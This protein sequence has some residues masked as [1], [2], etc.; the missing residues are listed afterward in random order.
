[1][2]WSTSFSVSGSRRLGRMPDRGILHAQSEQLQEVERIDRRLDVPRLDAELRAGNAHASAGA[3]LRDAEAQREHAR[4]VDEDARTA[5]LEV[6]RAAMRGS[7][8]VANA[9]IRPSGGVACSAFCDQESQ[10]HLAPLV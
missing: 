2:R 6:D 7:S 3:A 5:H 9:R 10:E 8:S 1:M 4:G